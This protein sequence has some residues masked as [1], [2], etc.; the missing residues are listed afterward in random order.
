[1][2]EVSNDS[3]ML[4]ELGMQGVMPNSMDAVADR[5]FVVEAIFALVLNMT[6]LSRFAEDLI[7]YSSGQFGYIQ[8]SDAYSTGSSLM[9]QKKNPDALELIRGKAGRMLVCIDFYVEHRCVLF[10]SSKRS[11]SVLNHKHSFLPSKMNHAVNITML[12]TVHRAM[13]AH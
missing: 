2:L 6:H 7:I 12:V 5:D 8:S 10:P 3:G 13:S 11:Q 1:M 4:Q 9:P